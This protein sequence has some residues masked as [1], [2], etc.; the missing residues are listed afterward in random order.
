MLQVRLR[1]ERPREDNDDQGIFGSASLDDHLAWHSLELPDRGNSP[2]YSCINPGLYVAKLDA[3]SKWS[4]RQDG[5]LYRLQ[6]VPGR[7][8]IKI[9]AAT[10]AGDVS[11]GWHSDL[12]GCIAL[13]KDIGTLQPPEV[14]MPQRC[15]LRSRIALKE[16][17]DA[18]GGEEIEVLIV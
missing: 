6:N 13:G 11:K 16:F 12:L 2:H 5:L 15:L 18:T 17:M 3:T 1:I 10:W 14:E 7:D 8:L 4:P 9:H